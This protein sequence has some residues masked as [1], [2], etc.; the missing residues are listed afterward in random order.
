MGKTL[1]EH[2][3]SL[4]YRICCINRGKVY[5]YLWSHS[6]MMRPSQTPASSGSVQTEE[7][8]R[9]TVLLSVLLLGIWEYHKSTNGRQLLTFAH[10][11]G[12]TCNLPSQLSKT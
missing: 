1:L 7:T 11:S 5:W 9:T 4:P 8:I 12:G 2:L 6:G 3:G 10:L